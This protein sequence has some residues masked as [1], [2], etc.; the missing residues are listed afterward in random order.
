MLQELVS[1]DRK[2]KTLKAELKEAEERISELK[3]ALL[4]Q[5]ADECCT[6]IKVDGRVIEVKPMWLASPL[7]AADLPAALRAADMSDLVHETCNA[8]SL[9][10]YV[11]DL[12]GGLGSPEEVHKL[13][14]PPLQPVL[15][16]YFIHRLEVMRRGEI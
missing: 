13:L 8:R 3:E 4:P 9:N 14:P 6:A 10:A 16:L 7:P 2:Q 11:K 5:F 12:A 1:L 15:K